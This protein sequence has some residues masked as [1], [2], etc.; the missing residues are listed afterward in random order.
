[1]PKTFNDADEAEAWLRANPMRELYNKDVDRVRFNPS[2][3]DLEFCYRGT[4]SWE[5]LFDGLNDYYAPYTV[6]E[7]KTIT[8]NGKACKEGDMLHS[9]LPE[10][11][12]IGH[13]V[14]DGIILKVWKE[15]GVFFH[16]IFHI[17]DEPADKPEEPK[18]LTFDSVGKVD[19]WYIEPLTGS[20]NYET[21][22]MLKVCFNLRDYYALKAHVADGHKLYASKKDAERAKALGWS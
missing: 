9:V 22:D 15:D 2:N 20:I 21:P 12:P 4:N 19:V 10:G 17:P 5:V 13:Y 16:Q 18:T 1:M 14:P 3:K 8:I 6:V 7:E 11:A